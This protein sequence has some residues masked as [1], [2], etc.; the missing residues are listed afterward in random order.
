MKGPR[1]I[2]I[3]HSYLISVQLQPAVG[4]FIYSHLKSHNRIIQLSIP[5]GEMELIK[6]VEKCHGLNRTTYTPIPI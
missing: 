3:I 2:L 1:I 4:T 5:L 6:G